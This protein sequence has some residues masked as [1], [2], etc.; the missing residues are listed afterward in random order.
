MHLTGDK[1]KR[2][3]KRQ[4]HQP[5]LT[6]TPSF[7]PADTKEAIRLAKSHTA[8]GLDEMSTFRLKKLAQG[9]I[10]YLTNIL[11][12][13]ISTG[14]IPEIWHKAIIIPILKTGKDNNI[15]QNWRSISLLCPAV[16]MLLKLLPPKILT[17]PFSPCSTWLLAETLDM[18]YT[19]DD[20]RRHC[21]RLLKIKDG[22]PNSARRARSDSCIRQCQPSTTARLCHQHQHTFNNPSQAL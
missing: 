16:I 12:L 2:Q 3:L 8:I 1:S 7:T 15:S 4:F 20:H 14:Q 11:N 17:H 9:A 13:S 21:C 5:P 6:G 22:S 10:N 18:H 19:V